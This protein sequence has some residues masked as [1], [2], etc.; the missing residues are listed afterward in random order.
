MSYF[1]DFP[2]TRYK[3]GNNLPEVYIQDIS[4]YVDLLDQLSDA[5]AFYQ[6]YTIL[7]GDRPDTL[8]YKLYGTTDYHW[9]F[10]LLNP[11]LRESGWPLSYKELES[12]LETAYPGISIMPSGVQAVDDG[13]FIS[14][15]LHLVF[16]DYFIVGNKYAFSDQIVLNGTSDSLF[17]QRID[18]GISTVI[19][20]KDLDLGTTVFRAEKKYND[21]ALRDFRTDAVS[22]I[23]VTKWEEGSKVIIFPL[24]NGTAFNLEYEETHHY[25]NASGEWVDVEYSEV[26]P[27]TTD[28]NDRFNYTAPI[29]SI[30]VTIKENLQAENDDAKVINIFKPSIIPEIVSQFK[31]VIKG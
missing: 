10:Y 7:D 20:Y 8:S 16:N 6:K 26:T 2:L 19:A 1:K 22:I 15:T 23:D 18:D 11:T 27:G 14:A 17:Q 28:V 12:S 5:T 25:E 9:T 29:G 31:K 24:N 13:G 3:F 30:P 4:I 21:Q